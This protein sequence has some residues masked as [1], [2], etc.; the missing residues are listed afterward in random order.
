MTPST[1]AS[2]AAALPIHSL[3]LEALQCPATEAA[4]HMRLDTKSG[5]VRHSMQP[6]DR[7]TRKIYLLTQKKNQVLGHI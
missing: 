7:S 6:F 1:T 5:K 4:L 2:K 3:L